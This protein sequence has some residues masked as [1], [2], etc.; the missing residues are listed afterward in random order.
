MVR[1]EKVLPSPRFDRGARGH[2]HGARFHT[3]VAERASHFGAS[4][5]G[6]DLLALV[7]ARMIALGV[8]DCVVGNK[9]IKNG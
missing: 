4:W 7:M 2:D 5:G 9:P 3:A 6:S 8:L 1:L